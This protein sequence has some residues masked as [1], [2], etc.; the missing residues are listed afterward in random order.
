MIR[1]AGDSIRLLHRLPAP[2]ERIGDINQLDQ[3]S[4][5]VPET[6]RGGRPLIGRVHSLQ[7]MGRIIREISGLAILKRTQRVRGSGCCCP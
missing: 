5:A 4:S 3:G 2:V 6:A 7:D 1:V